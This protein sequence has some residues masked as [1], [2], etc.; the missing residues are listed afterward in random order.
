MG[1]LM[2]LVLAKVF[3]PLYRFNQ[4]RIEVLYTL[5]LIE[6]LARIIRTE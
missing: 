1:I 2:T 6:V 5:S 3:L 4:E